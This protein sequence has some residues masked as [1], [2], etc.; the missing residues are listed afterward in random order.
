M[1]MESFEQRLK[2]AGALV[3]GLRRQ[4][5]LFIR[6]QRRPV[7]RDEAAQAVGI[8]RKLA[9][10]H[11]DKMVEK[12]LLTAHYTRLSGRSGPGAGRP[13]KVYEPSERDVSVSIPFRSYEV[14]GDVLLAALESSRRAR[15]AHGAVKEAAF[16]QGVELGKSVRR[17]RS[18]R[19]PSSKTQVGVVTEVLS[20]RGYEP[21]RDEGGNLRLHNCPFH[22]LAQRSPELVCGLNHAFIDGLLRGLGVESLAASLDPKP[23]ECCV[24]VRRGAVA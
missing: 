18:G 7:G 5:Y 4:M 9:A 6:E 24:Q 8:S 11:L 22:R 17:A 13:A 10:F 14:V 1:E 19:R 21:Y 23:G 16:E 20:E 2:S 12:G 3:D 15:P